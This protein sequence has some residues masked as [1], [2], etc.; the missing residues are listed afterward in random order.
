MITIQVEGK[1]IKTF[2]EN[3]PDTQW[4]VE[5]AAKAFHIASPFGITLRL[6]PKVLKTAPTKLLMVAMW[7]EIK[8]V[9]IKA[10]FVARKAWAK[11]QPQIV[12]ALTQVK[13]QYGLPDGMLGVVKN[14]EYCGISVDIPL[15]R[16]SLLTFEHNDL[17]IQLADLKFHDDAISVGFSVERTPG[18]LTRES[19]EDIPEESE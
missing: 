11:M 1:D 9:G 3:L 17:M 5:Y 18:I 19:D 2:V 7:P 4:G 8:A 10:G 6:R 13:E 14:D 12:T 15:L 16:T